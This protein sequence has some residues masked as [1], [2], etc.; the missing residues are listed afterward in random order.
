MVL[1]CRNQMEVFEWSYTCWKKITLIQRE[2]SSTYSLFI[3]HEIR[4]LF[5]YY[6]YQSNK[7]DKIVIELQLP[8]GFPHIKFSEQPFLVVSYFSWAFIL[9]KCLFTLVICQCLVIAFLSL[10]NCVRVSF[11]LRLS[12]FLIWFGL[13][14]MH[15]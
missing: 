2:N 7:C 10:S 12:C 13:L 1:V 5:T 8:S 15:F 3:D 11:K 4:H 14:L 9:S 6:C